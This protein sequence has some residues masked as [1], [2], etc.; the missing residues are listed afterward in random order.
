LIWTQWTW[1]PSPRSIGYDGDENG[2]WRQVQHQI[3]IHLYAQ[4]KAKRSGKAERS[5]EGCSGLS[6]DYEN[7]TRMRAEEGQAKRSGHVER[8]EERGLG[9]FPD[10]D[11]STRTHAEEGQAKRSGHAERCGEGGFGGLPDNGNPTRMHA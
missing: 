9:A 10:Y 7:P 6:P 5:G 3:P 4:K 8:S 1:K 11:N 2:P